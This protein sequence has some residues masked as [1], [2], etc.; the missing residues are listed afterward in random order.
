[1]LYGQFVYSVMRTKK[2]WL[3]FCLGMKKISQWRYFSSD[4]KNS[5]PQLQSVPLKISY[6]L[7]FRFILLFLLSTQ[8]KPRYFSHT[9]HCCSTSIHP[10]SEQSVVAPVSLKPPSRKAQT[11]LIGQPHVPEQ[12]PPTVFHHQLSY[13]FNNHGRAGGVADGLK[14]QFP[15]LYSIFYNSYTCFIT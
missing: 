3:F 11:V 15:F 1:M 12:V 10:L 2:V 9:V 4:K 5:S 8:K 14:A 7:I 6:M 13:H